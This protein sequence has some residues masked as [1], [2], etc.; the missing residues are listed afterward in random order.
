MRITGILGARA[1]ILSSSWVEVDDTTNG[2][3]CMEENGR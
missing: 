1:I 3:F 2:M